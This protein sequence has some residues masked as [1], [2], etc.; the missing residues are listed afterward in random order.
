MK[1]HPISRRAALLVAG[2]ILGVPTVSAEAPNPK[3]PVP[4]HVS[5]EAQAIL[6]QPVDTSRGQLPPPSTPEEWKK[7]VAAREA[8]I[9]PL[10]GPLLARAPISVEKRQIAGVTV[11]ELRPTKRA[12]RP[13]RLLMN[14]HGGGY[15]MLGGDLSYAEGVGFASAGYRVIAVDY[16]MPPDHPFPAAVDDGVA[17]YRA[18]LEKHAP[19]EI[20]IF[21]GSAGGGLTA[22]VVIAARDAGLPLPAAVIL[23]T[24]WADLSKTGD[25]YYA[26]EGVD[27]VLS[28]YD[29]LLEAGAILY[30]GDAG[31]EHPLV[32]PVYADYSKGF[33]P[34]MLTTG[35]RDLLL[36]ATVRLHRAMREAGVEADLHVWDAM[37]HGIVGIPEAREL[38]EEALRFLDEHLGG[39]SGS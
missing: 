30:A 23:N 8:E 24:P 37:W 32:S 14:L 4:T 2:L 26:N 36:S 38:H 3:Y 13:G 25:S 31:L 28:I 20:A 10:F 35:T 29:G 34:A 9:A 16:R 7:Q 18:L 33:P 5:P 27:P 12:L 19:N 6:S 22:A 17:V 21:G 1:P 39:G 15:T 11:R